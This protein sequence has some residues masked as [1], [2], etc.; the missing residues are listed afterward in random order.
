MTGPRCT[1]APHGAAANAAAIH[2]AS[3][4]VIET[5]RLRLRAPSLDDLPDWTAVFREAFAHGARRAATRAA[6]ARLG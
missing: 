1:Q 4:P 2:R 6:G 3:V 5:A